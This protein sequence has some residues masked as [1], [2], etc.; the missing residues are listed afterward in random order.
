MNLLG[1]DVQGE[2]RT[3]VVYLIWGRYKNYRGFDQLCDRLEA[4]KN[5]IRDQ[6]KEKLEFHGKMLQ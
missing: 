6:I 2:V 3:E 1:E 5:D 4:I